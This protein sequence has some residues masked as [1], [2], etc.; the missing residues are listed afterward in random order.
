MQLGGPISRDKAFWWASVQRY[1]FEQDPAG[2]RTKS[3]E[4]SPRYNGKLTFN[5]TPNDVLV[6]A[7]SSTTTTT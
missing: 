4:I 1:S 7:V 2:T 6:T 3:T 5:L